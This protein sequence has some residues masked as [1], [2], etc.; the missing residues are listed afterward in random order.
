MFFNLFWN[1]I[2][3]IIPTAP[4]RRVCASWT[5]T[6]TW[7]CPRPSAP[8]TRAVATATRYSSST[9]E[10]ATRRTRPNW[11]GPGSEPR[12]RP[13]APGRRR[14]AWT[15]ATS[16]RPAQVGTRT[17]T[18][19]VQTIKRVT[20]GPL[21]PSLTASKSCQCKTIPECP[22]TGPHMFCVKLSAQ[23]T[24]SVTLCATAALRCGNHQFEILNEGVCE[25]GWSCSFTCRK[26]A[27]KIKE[28]IKKFIFYSSTVKTLMRYFIWK[29]T[30][31]EEKNL[32]GC[33]K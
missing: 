25:S 13:R 10:R 26:T 8:S 3:L 16:G 18:R 7:P 4:I 30:R 9:R 23:R 5:W 27:L 14:A 28:N 6:S 22:R 24:R 2:G 1:P 15:R 21:F 20:S 12:C 33:I 32:S 17:R 31:K 29:Q 11:T 19:R